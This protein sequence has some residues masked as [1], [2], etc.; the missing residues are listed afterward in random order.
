[1]MT[2]II[3]KKEGGRRKRE[4]RFL[5]KVRTRQKEIEKQNKTKQNVEGRKERESSWP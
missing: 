3:M 2:N 5:E 4:K 1:M